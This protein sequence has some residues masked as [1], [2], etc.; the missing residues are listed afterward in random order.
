MEET[1]MPRSGWS[2]ALR[3]GLPG[4]LLGLALASG[5]RG[6][7]ELWAQVA[8]SGPAPVSLAMPAGPA[9][10]RPRAAAVAPG[11][12][13]DGTIAFTT[14][15]NGPIQLLYLIDTRS[16]AF[17]IYRVDSTKGTV[18][19]DA[20]RQYGWDLKLT[21]YNNLEPQVTAIESMVKSLG[22]P[23]NPNR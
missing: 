22:Q 2:G 9:F 8:T 13:G 20:A 12:E 10:D 7:R 16:R 5:G 11:G 15:P 18:K 17:M 14:N 6:G 23:T 19:L 21:A 3:Y 1:G 4:L